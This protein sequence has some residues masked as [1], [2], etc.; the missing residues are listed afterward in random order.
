MAQTGE[1]SSN[2]AMHAQ[3][4]Q[5]V[6]HSSALSGPEVQ[7]LPIEQDDRDLGPGFLMDRR[8]TARRFARAGAGPDRL[9]FHHRRYRADYS[10]MFL[11]AQTQQ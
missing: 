6:H 9:A 11:L 4:V 10:G 2:E 5:D 1:C 8:P 7:D 3:T